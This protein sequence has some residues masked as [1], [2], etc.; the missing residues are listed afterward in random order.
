[1]TWSGTFA[2]QHLL[3]GGRL[4]SENDDAS[5]PA[6][7]SEIKI[8]LPARLTHSVLRAWRLC[9]C[10]ASQPR[11]GALLPSMTLKGSHHPHVLV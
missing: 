3:V 8:I 6:P 4:N 9:L 7:G 1:M 2:R 10:R 5:L 11:P